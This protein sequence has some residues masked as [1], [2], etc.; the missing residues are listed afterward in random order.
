MDIL[1]IKEISE[2]QVIKLC[3]KCIIDGEIKINEDK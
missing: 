1:K 3:K 2:E